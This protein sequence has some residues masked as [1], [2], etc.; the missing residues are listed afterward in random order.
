MKC[1]RDGA[2]CGVVPIDDP[3]HGLANHTFDQLAETELSI[4]AEI[5]LA[6]ETERTTT[7]RASLFWD[8]S[9]TRRRATI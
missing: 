4:C 2:D 7:P 3:E 9:P 8:G 5:L 6:S 1:E